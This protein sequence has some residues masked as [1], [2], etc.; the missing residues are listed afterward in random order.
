MAKNDQETTVRENLQ[1]A[2]TIYDGIREM[3]DAMIAAAR[4]GEAR[5]SPQDTI[6]TLRDL[7][8]A[9]TLLV[10]AERKFHAASK[11]A[12]S[13]EYNLDDIRDTIGR[14]LDRIRATRGAD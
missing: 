11:T 9:Q 6:A 14:K 10:R 5:F 7:N 2:Q 13:T 4:A 3:L 1:Q 8:H 12:Q